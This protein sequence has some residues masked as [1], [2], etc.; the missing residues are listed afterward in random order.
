MRNLNTS[1]TE[2][3]YILVKNHVLKSAD[4]KLA[5]SENQLEHQ[6]RIAN[7]IWKSGDIQFV[8]LESN[9]IT[10]EDWYDYQAG[11]DDEELHS[12]ADPRAIN[13]YWMNS[14][15]VSTTAVCGYAY[16]PPDVP[17]AVL[18]GNG[19]CL[20]TTLPHE[21]GHVLGLLHTHESGDE[22]VDGSNCQIA[23]DLVCDTPADPTLRYSTVDSSCRYYGTARDAKGQ[24]YHPDTKNIMSYSRKE[25]RTSFTPG[26]FKRVRALSLGDV[27][28]RASI[29]AADFKVPSG[30]IEPGSKVELVGYCSVPG[31]FSWGLSAGLRWGRYETG[32]NPTVN[33]VLNER[34]LNR[35]EMKV[36][37]D[38][39]N[40]C[41]SRVKDVM[42][43]KV[44]SS[45]ATAIHLS[46]FILIVILFLL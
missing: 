9:I 20:T 1:S 22:L 29:I 45:G 42:V 14:V 3:L 11:E 10:N 5:I 31:N 19:A 46:F 7:R 24:L 30:Y 33:I 32:K 18:S 8:L 44:S 26:Q 13:I 6:F 23:G 21:I 4:G 43:G 25:C 34:G 39:M 37:L 15:Y 38:S 40:V 41:I 12:F 28:R 2:P 36:C 17:M 35:I 27:R 16:L